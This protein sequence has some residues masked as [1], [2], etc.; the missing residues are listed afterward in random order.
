MN[1]KNHPFQSAAFYETLFDQ[2]PS[3]IAVQGQDGRVIRANETFCRMFGY[4]QE[5]VV[6]SFLDELV[7]RD[8]ELAP[9]AARISERAL[10]GDPFSMQ[11]VRIRK[12]GTRFPVS[13][14]GVPITQE[15]K[16]VAV[17]AIYEDISERRRI[18]DTLAAERNYF[19]SLFENSPLAIALIDRSGV[20]QRVN[21]SF[22]ELFGYDVKECVGERLDELIAP[23]KLFDDAAALTSEVASGG[24]VKTE[25]SRHKKDGTWIDVQIQAMPFEGVGGQKVLYAIY[26]D[27]TERKRI[28]ENAR[29]LGYH[30][31]LTG[32]YNLAFLEE[33]TQRLD[34]P[35]QLPLSVIMAD[36]D[37]L[38]LVN[39]AFGHMEGDKMILDV[40]SILRSCCRQEDIIARCGGDE[41]VLILPRTTLLEARS[42]CDRIREASRR[43]GGHSLMP[44]SIALGVA[45]KDEVTQD[46][47]HVRKKA[48][49]DMYLDKLLR[50]E[51]SRAAI[52]RRL[53][54]FLYF[55][56]RRKAH[57]ERMLEL[58][59]FFGKFLSLRKDE[60]A[61]LEILAK[62]HDVGLMPVPVE[63]LYREG[64]LTTEETEMIRKH[65]ERGYHIAK[66][67]PDISTVADCILSHQETYD[68]KGYPRR[69]SGDDIPLPA[70]IIHLLCAYEVM[71]GWRPY[72]PLVSKEEA[73]REIA[74]LA[75]SQFDPRLTGL[76]IKMEDPI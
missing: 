2:A 45:V 8:R 74:S 50:S 66:N 31:N 19:E 62:F 37:N 27:I 15:G 58:V 38:K 61:N 65:P 13:I 33:E 48:D 5:E 23:G 57:I 20:I 14:K 76:F 12:D 60:I 11:T 52:F 54:D 1:D 72:G 4:S 47:M 24:L 51:K 41:F 44:P 7:A 26:Q 21:T 29:Y 55:D 39:D 34:T 70:R 53:E 71:T 69:L 30:D 40:G 67:L 25:R 43:G 22:V 9:V 35:R 73:L 10:K 64:P 18:E 17:Y 16:I 59:A 63:I 42:V 56:P 46:F 36:L 3:G 49:D 28:E 68:G 6:G 75:G 32:L